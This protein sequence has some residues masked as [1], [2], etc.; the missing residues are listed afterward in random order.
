[1]SW[2][3]KR[4]FIKDVD[5]LGTRAMVYVIGMQSND[6]N[7]MIIVQG[8]YYDGA[9]MV[10]IPDQELVLETPSGIKLYAHPNG[11]IYAKYF[12]ESFAKAIPEFF[13]IKNLSE[14]RFTRMIVMPDGT[15]L[16]LSANR[17]ISDERLEELVESLVEI[18][19]N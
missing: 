10:W 1:L 12:L 7:I 14:E 11:T 13:D 18:K 15:I 19:A 17:Q 9:R 8:N 4:V 5:P 3:E 2:I 16:G 6:G